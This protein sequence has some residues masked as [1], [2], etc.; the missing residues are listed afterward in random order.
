MACFGAAASLRVSLDLARTSSL[1][2]NRQAGARAQ[3][4]PRRY[5]RNSRP[6]A[7]PRSSRVR[8]R[9]AHPYAKPT[10]V[11]TLQSD[12]GQSAAPLSGRGRWEGAVE[13]VQE[14]PEG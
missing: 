13:V 1:P 11:A 2:L 14:N 9:R 8:T 4:A 12:S 6:R 7:G 5:G 3:K 10:R